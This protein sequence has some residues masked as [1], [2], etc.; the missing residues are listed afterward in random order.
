MCVSILYEI[1]IISVICAF[2]EGFQCHFI[3]MPPFEEEEV[4]CFA[5]VGRSV[6]PSVRPPGGF[7]MITQEFLGLGS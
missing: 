2:L 1:S 3:F 4:Y 6:G 5:H 7:R